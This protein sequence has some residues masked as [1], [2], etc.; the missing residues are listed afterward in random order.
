MA[1]CGTDEPNG[2][3]DGAAP[4]L[5]PSPAPSPQTTSIDLLI[6]HFC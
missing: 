2:A 3:C 6:E 1:A 5:V 4:S